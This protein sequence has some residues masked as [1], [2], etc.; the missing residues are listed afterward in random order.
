MFKGVADRVNLS[1]H[2]E[3]CLAQYILY[4]DQSTLYIQGTCRHDTSSDTVV[5]MLLHNAHC[6]GQRLKG[7]YLIARGAAGG[8]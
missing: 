7:V 2:L 4:T 6:K 5:D 1:Q 8:T 3:A